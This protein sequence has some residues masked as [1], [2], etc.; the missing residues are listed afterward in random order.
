MTRLTRRRALQVGSGVLVG[1]A[2]CLGDSDGTE[3]GTTTATTTTTTTEDE[4]TTTSSTSPHLDWTRDLQ[5]MS[6][7]TEFEGTVLFG[8]A[9]GLLHAMA[10]DGTDVWTFD[11]GAPVRRIEVAEDTIYVMSGSRSGAHLSGST[12][13]AVE[14]DG[15]ERRWAHEV[16]EGYRT[17]VILGEAQGVL[18]VGLRN[19]MIEESGEATFGL[20]VTDGTEVWRR[21]TGDVDGGVAGPD[22]IYAAT[23]GGVTA[24]DPETGEERWTRSED[25]AD[26]PML[27]GDHA[28]M[29]ADDVVA[30]APAT[31]KPRWTYGEDVDLAGAYVTGDRI[32]ARGAIVA[33]LAPDGTEQWRYEPGGWVTAH[34]D[35]RLFGADDT[36]LFALTADGKEAWTAENPAEYFDLTAATDS[37]VAGHMEG[38]VI[39]YDQADGSVVY[40]FDIQEGHAEK[41]SAVG[42]RLLASDSETLYGLEG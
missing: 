15:S 37:L 32:Y 1:L 6:G 30:L 36:R 20:D 9:S 2:G 42:D 40:R 27:V 5:V 8:D 41:L 19:D 13:H 38:T 4:T 39:A 17:A 28:I 24:F 18:G 29:A 11:V 31:G 35:G 34:A 33:E 16:Q 23:Y 21:E 10:P 14:R 25:F 26:A 3:Q 22:T 7:F 12:V